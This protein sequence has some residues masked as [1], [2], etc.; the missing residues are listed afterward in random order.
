MGH[1]IH[2]YREATREMGR[3]ARSG[4]AEEKVKERCISAGNMDEDRE[5]ARVAGF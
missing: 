5:T 4:G 3:R 2:K 1:K